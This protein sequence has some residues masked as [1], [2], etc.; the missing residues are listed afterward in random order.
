VTSSA[1]AVTVVQSPNQFHSEITF[2]QPK[3]ASK[4]GSTVISDGKKVWMYR[5]DLKQYAVLSLE[6]FIDS[7]DNYWIGMSSLWFLQ[8]PPEF[9]KPLADG[10]LSDPKL[11]K[12]IG[13]TDDL[14]F[15]GSKQTVNG[16]ELYAYEYSDK[17]GFAIRTYVEPA[18]ATVKQ[19]V[20]IG[21]SEGYDVVITERILRRTA[22]LTTTASTFK[23]FPP[24]GTKLVK[25]LSIGPL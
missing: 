11:Q 15:T 25:S 18:T 14:L 6:K 16:Q 13:L 2:S 21:K 7:D 10:A 12:E 19:V 5:P 1:K 8:I 3:P 20:V 23:F 24:V 4:S 22:N 17:N 9:R